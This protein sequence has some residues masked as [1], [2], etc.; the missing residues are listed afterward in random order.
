[1]AITSAGAGSGLDLEGII[2]SS[3]AAK[4]AQLQSPVLIKQDT[5]KV[6]LSGLGQLKSAV[7][8][9]TD[10]MAK[11][12]EPGAFNKRII[13]ITQS[14][15][16]P[17][18]K[19]EGKA[20]AA[21]GQY[22]ITVNQL[23]QSSRQEG[24][25]DSATMPL[26][27]EDGELSFTA[28]DKTFK[29]KVKAGDTLQ[30][31]RKSINSHGDNFGLTANIV[32]TANGKAKLVIDSG[33]SGEGNDLKI[34]GSNDSINNGFINQLTQTQAAQDA[35]ID[36]D[37]VKLKSHSNTFD[38][39][40]QG[41]KIT[42]LRTSDTT[43]SGDLKSNKVDI[44]TDKSTLV[45][46]AQ[47]FI[48]SYN[49]LQDTLT[50]LGKRST[51]VDGKKQDDGGALEGDATTRLISSFLSNTLMAPSTQSESFST[52]FE[53]GINMDKSG[54]LSL[55]K[56]KFEEKVDT[57][58]DQVVALFG[59]EQGLAKN[60]QD[61]LKDYTK[62]GGLLAQRTDEL[63]SVQRRLSQQEADNN[64]VLQKY[65][66]SLRAQYGGLDALLVK[67]NQSLNYLYT[68]QT[69]SN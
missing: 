38:D 69:N 15:D 55:D 6:M 24:V 35:M 28:G 9:F 40:I 32:N 14:K 52:L 17:I 21:N 49:E 4:K 26:F 66:A 5:N 46:Q 27:S 68:I 60:L 13:N 37:G 42:V 25:F 3:V 22:N 62:S 67:M 29:V 23:A 63:N 31:L 36:V 61:G 10:V 43:S 45:T 57:N 7:T 58:F 11:L 39:T 16:D 18:L 20:D 8:K 41:L 59:G 53:V 54:K 30:S 12:S 51:M 64:V 19:V 47:S 2:A 56:K 1:M 65:E 34:T 48:D 44:S 33:V 50:A